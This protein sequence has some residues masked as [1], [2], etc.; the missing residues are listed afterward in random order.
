[1]DQGVDSRLYFQGTH[2]SAL[3]TFEIAGK[4][5]FASLAGGIIDGSGLTFAYVIFIILAAMMMPFF[6]FGAI[7]QNKLNLN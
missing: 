4:L 6:Y 5:I 2:F 1:L 7:P 3:A